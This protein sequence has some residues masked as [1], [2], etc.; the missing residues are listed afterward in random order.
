MK[1]IEKIV[2]FILDQY[3]ALLL[4]IA[5]LFFISAYLVV[6]EIKVENS[7]KIWF[8]DNDPHYGAY[9]DFQEQYGNDD[10]VTIF[11]EYPE[12][13]ICEESARDAEY[14]KS[15]LD[16]LDFIDKVYTVF[17]AD[18]LNANDFELN[19]EQV[20]EEAPQTD[21]ARQEIINRLNSFPVI[22]NTFLTPDQKGHVIIARLKPVDQI[23]NKRDELIRDIKA[24]AQDVYP[25]VNM[26]G[27]AVLT[28][29]LN[30]RV[31]EETSVFTSLSYLIIIVLLSFFIRKRRYLLIAIPSVIVPIAVLFGIFV[32]AG[33]KL[34]MISMIIPT[35][36]LVYSIADVVHILNIYIL[37]GQIYKTLP[38]R[39]IIKK[40]L[41]YSF[42]PCMFTSVTTM[43]GYVSFT[44]SP[45]QAL[46]T[47]GIF[48]FLG[49]GLAFVLLYILTAAGLMILN[50]PEDEKEWGI[51][52]YFEKLNL[53][54]SQKV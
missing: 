34:N 33:Y 14:I 5:V 47:T 22:K 51:S 18:F 37:Y 53:F 13:A 35:I 42:I 50:V 3:K 30:R 43:A 6:T 36:L 2:D 29:A 45:F 1:I 25:E 16:S 46:Q 17:S 44:L 10:I 26:G 9:L 19:I 31:A 23:E 38:K 7:L 49:V 20:A 4:I 8:L 48:A 28:E 39:D 12:S 40:S 41:V 24:I 27:I 15:R 52:L 21:S 54:I 32:L 11:A